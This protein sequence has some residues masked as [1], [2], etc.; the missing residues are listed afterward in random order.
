MMM[1]MMM[2]MIAQ[3]GAL[4]SLADID[5]ALPSFVTARLRVSLGLLL[6]FSPAAAAADVSDLI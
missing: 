1:M 4:D 2:M 5:I 3:I 6:L